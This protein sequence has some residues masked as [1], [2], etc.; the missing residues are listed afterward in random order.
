MTNLEDR[1]KWR[2]KQ[3]NLKI[4]DLVLLEENNFPPLKWKTGH[5]IEMHT[6]KDN[7]VTVRTATGVSKRAITKLRKLPVPSP[8]D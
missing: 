1:V 4:N 5:V 8:S 2:T 3:E 6:V 7:L